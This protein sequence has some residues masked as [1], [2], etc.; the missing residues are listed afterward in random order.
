MNIKDIIK[1]IIRGNGYKLQQLTP[2]ND[3]WTLLD[4]L[5]VENKV[6]VV[7][8]VGANSGQFFSEFCQNST[9][10]ISEYVCF[11]PLSEVFGI[12]KDTV[13]SKTNVKFDVKIN[14][15][16]LGDFTGVAE[17]NITPNLVSSSLMRPSVKYYNHMTT[18]D[19]KL[20]FENIQVYRFDDF[21]FKSKNDGIES[22]ICNY[23][24]NNYFLKIDTQGFELKVLKGFGDYLNLAKVVLLECSLVESYTDRPLLNDIVLY[25][26]KNGFCVSG[27]FQGYFDDN[28]FQLYEVDVVFMRLDG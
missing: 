1:K 8:D 5:M 10:N 25:M 13:K 19:T 11:E 12:L 16:A 4:R 2:I 14:N 3:M 26:E 23:K 20:K 7:F 24:E 22:A 17:L 28:T 9:N 27:I 21:I 18:V 15:V 6:N